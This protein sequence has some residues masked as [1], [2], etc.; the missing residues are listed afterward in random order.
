MLGQQTLGNRSLDRYRDS[1]GKL[2]ALGTDGTILQIV[3]SVRRSSVVRSTMRN[4]LCSCQG[5]FQAASSSEPSEQLITSLISSRPAP[6]VGRAPC[7]SSRWAGVSGSAPPSGSSGEKPDWA[8]Q[9]MYGT[10]RSYYVWGSSSLARRLMLC[11]HYVLVGH[12]PSY[13][14]QSGS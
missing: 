4:S 3:P 14:M 2:C 6:R 9:M 12:F 7:L 11:L 5:P 8:E 10:S 13:S 1:C